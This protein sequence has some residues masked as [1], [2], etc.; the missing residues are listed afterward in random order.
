MICPFAPI[1]PI[2]EAPAYPRPH[3]KTL[4]A[5][6]LYAPT[7]ELID[8]SR[9]DTA[10]CE[11]LT[12]LWAEGKTFLII[13]HDIEIYPNN[14]LTGGVV[15][16]AEWCPAMWC[17]WPFNGA[18]FSGEGD[19]LLYGSLG[20]T[21]FSDKLMKLEP[22][23]MTV[24]GAATGGLKPGDWRRMDVSIQPELRDRGYT[25]HFHDPVKHHKLY[26]FEGC[27]CGDPECR[28]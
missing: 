11:L 17:V 8:V 19:A 12:R 27:A 25:Q 24:A 18:G 22:D 28:P 20:C 15:R 21:L 1:P 26:P 23:L 13:E 3:P 4:E 7:A 14:Q 2:G 10:Y 9:S 5:L 6:R 16:E